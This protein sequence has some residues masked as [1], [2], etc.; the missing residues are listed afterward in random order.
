MAWLNTAD[1]MLRILLRVP[2]VKVR[3]FSHNST[4]TVRTSVNPFYLAMPE[5]DQLAD[6]RDLILE[7]LHDRIWILL[8]QQASPFL[9][10][11]ILHVASKKN[12]Y[13]RDILQVMSSEEVSELILEHRDVAFMPRATAWRIA[14]DEITMRPLSEPRLRLVTNLA[15]RADSKSRLVKEFVRATS[16]KLDS[17]MPKQQR[18]LPR[19]RWSLLFVRSRVGQMARP[20]IKKILSRC[21]PG[22]LIIERVQL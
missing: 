15:V 4:S 21:E 7:Q 5:D 8:S 2:G 11:N 6:R 10:D 9:Y 3:E 16:G 1:M 13:P 12:V 20:F 18:Q 22:V 14:R 19:P 17:M